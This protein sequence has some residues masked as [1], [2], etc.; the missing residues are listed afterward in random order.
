MRKGLLAVALCGVTGS[1]LAVGDIEILARTCNNCHGVSGVSAG[2]SMPSI[3]G[4]P[5]AYLSKIMKEWKYDKRDAATMNRIVKGLTDDEINALAVY[6]SKK[7]WVP[8]PQRASAAAMA[9]GKQVI[10]ENCEDCHGATGS[11]PDIDA[12]KINGQAAR[13]MALELEKYRD[14]AFEMPHRKMNKIVRKLNGG[15]ID[16]VSDYYGAQRK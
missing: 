4:L 1:A 13:Y 8:L 9:K 7:R 15:E 3:G 16:A 11:D 6:F 10:F 2:G 5:S 12:P 14:G